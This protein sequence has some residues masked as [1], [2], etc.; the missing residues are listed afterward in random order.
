MIKIWG[1]K[2]LALC[3]AMLSFGPAIASDDGPPLPRVLKG[4]LGMW[5][6]TLD[7]DSI[8]ACIVKLRSGNTIGG[9]RLDVPK[10]CPKDYPME[11]LS[12][13]NAG[14]GDEIIFIDVLRHVVFRFTQVEDGLYTT[15]PDK[16]PRYTLSQPNM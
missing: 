16:P 4:M 1:A 6:L 3:L 14:T 12:A 7:D 13:W 9:Y 15:D 10:A 8:P 11:N 5:S 2:G